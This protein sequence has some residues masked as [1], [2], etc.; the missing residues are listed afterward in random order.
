MIQ[1]MNDLFH[2]IKKNFSE[3]KVSTIIILLLWALM[4]VFTLYINKDI[5]GKISSGSES[6]DKVMELTSDVV[7]SEVMPVQ[8]DAD[9]SYLYQG[10]RTSMKE[11]PPVK[12]GGCSVSCR[13]SVVGIVVEISLHQYHGCSLVTGTAGQVA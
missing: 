10:I 13:I 12:T 4:V 9:A 2:R 11:H 5:L 1:K 8:E 7:A 3:N 6:Y